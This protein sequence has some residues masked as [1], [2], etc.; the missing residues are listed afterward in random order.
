MSVE[1][2]T[3][4]RAR[5]TIEVDLPELDQILEQTRHAPLN[6]EDYQK[7]KHALHILRRLIQPTR[8]TEKTSAVLA[9]VED[10]VSTKPIVSVAEQDSRVGH[11]RNGAAALTGARRVAI[12]HTQLQSGEC[13]PAC[14]RGKVYRQKKSK[15]LVRIIG[16]APLAATVYELERLRCNACGQVFTAEKPEEVG[17]DQYDETT[18]AM[19]AQLKYGSGMP[20]HEGVKRIV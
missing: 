15:P 11:G 14:D 1:P 20:F 17:S 12:R 9:K 3:M 18:A 16:Q 10:Q 7:L 4:K 13:C 5:Q 19:I 8:N 2:I 6:E